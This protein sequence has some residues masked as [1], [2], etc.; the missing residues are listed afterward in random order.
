[1]AF[2]YDEILKR[3]GESRRERVVLG[4]RLLEPTIEGRLLF[5]ASWREKESDE[6][7]RVVDLIS[8]CAV[9]DDGRLLFDTPERKATLRS[10]AGGA[11]ARELF[12]ACYDL[13]SV[14][15]DDVEVAVGESEGDPISVRSTNSPESS[16]SPIPTPS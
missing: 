10:D 6:A 2:G 16:A 14:T 3:I 5:E 1:M 13:I 9:D 12:D 4:V 8:V 7:A 15:K 11:F